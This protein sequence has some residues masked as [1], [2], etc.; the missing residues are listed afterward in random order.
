MILTLTLTI[1]LAGGAY[2]QEQEDAE[3]IDAMSEAAEMMDNAEA[4]CSAAITPAEDDDGTPIEVLDTPDRENFPACAAYDNMNAAY[5]QSMV[6]QQ[7][8]MLTIAE[9]DAAANVAYSQ[10]DLNLAE[11]D[12]AASANTLAATRAIGTQADAVAANDLAAAEAAGELAAAEAENAL[13][14]AAETDDAAASFFP[15][16]EDARLSQVEETLNRLTGYFDRICTF[17]PD[18]SWCR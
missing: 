4:A 16:E 9:N 8:A 2:A 3:T 1:L 7:N 10:D 11:N 18:V 14:D 12:A 5:W 6:V 17:N 13:A 15:S